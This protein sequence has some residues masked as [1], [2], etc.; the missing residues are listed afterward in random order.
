MQALGYNGAE[1]GGVWSGFYTVN[2]IAAQ[3]GYPTTIV[4]GPYGGY[5]GGGGLSG[6]GHGTVII[7]G[8]VNVYQGSPY[9][10]GELRQFTRTRDEFTRVLAI[11]PFLDAEAVYLYSMTDLVT[12]DNGYEYTTTQATP[13]YMHKVSA[14]PVNPVTGGAIAAEAFQGWAGGTWSVGTAYTASETVR[15]NVVQRVVSSSGAHNFTLD[16]TS[17]FFSATETVGRTYDTWGSASGSSLYSKA[18]SVSEGMPA[19]IDGTSPFSF[20]GW[21]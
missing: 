7:N 5:S 6:M 13:A 16:S 20:V 17:E 8:S 21:A 4:V 10:N 1:P 2:P 14:T 15:S 18:A 9:A 3:N 12:V 19:A 11:V